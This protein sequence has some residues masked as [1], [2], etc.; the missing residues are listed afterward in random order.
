MG[1]SAG[2]Q[3]VQPLPPILAGG[4]QLHVS[5]R[6]QL[7]VAQLGDRAGLAL[8]VAGDH[9]R[10]GL[11]DLDLQ[12]VAPDTLAIGLAARFETMPSTPMRTASK[13]AAPLP[14][15]WSTTTTLGQPAA[16]TRSRNNA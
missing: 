1:R 14:K 9:K 3:Q 13:S 8:D 5:G 6:H 4:T 10:T 12:P 11:A 7:T 15:A 16:P 2:A